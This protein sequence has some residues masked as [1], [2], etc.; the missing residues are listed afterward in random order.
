MAKNKENIS[1]K[2]TLIIGICL[3]LVLCSGIFIGAK[4]EKSP[5]PVSSHVS[6]LLFT[7]DAQSGTF[8]RKSEGTY[9]LTLNDIAP[10][11]LFFTDRP[12][13]SVGDMDMETFTK[14]LWETKGKPDLPN[15]ILTTYDPEKQHVQAV[16]VTLTEPTYDTSI[17]RVSYIATV[18]PNGFTHK[19]QGQS[20]DDF[21]STLIK[22][23]LFIDGAKLS[24]QTVNEG[25]IPAVSNINNYRVGT[26]PGDP[27]FGL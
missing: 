16:V 14:T 19:L 26:L 3:L 12:D 17:G 4:L 23:T 13:R 9:I 25:F 10:H 22:P 21:P 20:L 24:G 8:V 27:Q 2:K 6:E 5:S 7:Q 11:V 18:L 15:A 1:I